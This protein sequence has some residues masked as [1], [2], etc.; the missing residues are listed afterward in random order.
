VR[1]D[2]GIL[3][4]ILLARFRAPNSY[5]GEDMAELHCHGNPGLL[6]EILKALI[7]Q[8]IRLAEPG[9]FT[10]RAFRNGRLSLLQAESVAELID[11]RGEWARRNALSVLAESGDAWV[12]ELL[13]AILAIW[14]PVES[15]LEFPTDDLDSLRLDTFLPALEALAT[16]LS[17]LEQRSTRYAKLQE[18]YRV[19]LAGAPNAGK[20]SLLN[21]LLG[22][23]RALVTEIP[24]TTR[25]TLEEQFDIRGIPIRLIDTAGLGDAH[26]ALDAHGMER[27]REALRRADLAVVVIDVAEEPAGP[28]LSPGGFLAGEQVPEG[29]PVILAG[30]KCDLLSDESP[31]RQVEGVHL[32]SAK[33][34][35]G[36]DQ[37][38]D[39]IGETLTGSG[40]VHLE[41]RIML[42]QRQAETLSRT[43]Q[44]ITRATQNIRT[45]ASQDL[46][47]TDLRDA[48]TALEELS[49][50]T[51]QVD[52]LETI[53]S[54]F[55]IGK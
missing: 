35:T 29:C 4:E 48:K 36:L 1:S 39:S 11:S 13:D 19:V 8:G 12:R 33:E 51:I 41:E 42:N 27:S 47:A 54:R 6:A 45:S 7:A 31:W 23:S 18:G 53:F 25:D 44:A 43:S 21:A 20:S 10:C 5:T 22:Y 34:E 32:V 37:L 38:I 26:D 2:G 3:D 9:E 55:C 16:R 50:K 40:V 14:V 30:N 15:D 28:D 52:L 24:G 46:V 49:G 17:D